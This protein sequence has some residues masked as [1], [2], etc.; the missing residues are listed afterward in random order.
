M[1][2][3][4]GRSVAKIVQ[5]QLSVGGTI[6]DIRKALQEGASFSRSR[7]RLVARTETTRAWNGA[8]RRSLSDWVDEQPEGVHVTKEWISSRD[9]RVR[10]EH[11]VMDGEKVGINKLFS[12]G[13]EGPGEPNCRCTTIYGV[14]GAT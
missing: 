10:D 6:S 3:T 13:L 12:N 11:I 2:S 9:D 8:Q 1:G 14:E 4:T 7:A 5:D